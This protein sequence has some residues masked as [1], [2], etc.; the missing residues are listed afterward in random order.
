MRTIQTGRG[1]SRTSLT[2]DRIAGR[3]STLLDTA[4]ERELFRDQFAQYRDRVSSLWAAS[5]GPLE[6]ETLGRIARD[7]GSIHEAAFIEAL[8]GLRAEGAR[9]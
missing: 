7:H 4:D 5:A 6:I 3:R 9:L 1:I 2:P 8:A